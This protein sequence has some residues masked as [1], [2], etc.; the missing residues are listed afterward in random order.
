LE[1][2]RTAYRQCGV[3]VTYQMQSVQL[4][5]V[6]GFDPKCQGR[7]SFSSQQA[8]LRRLDKAMQAFFRRVKARQTPGYPRFRGVGWFNT[9]EF[10]KDG[11][12]VRWDATPHDPVTRV[13]L[14]GVGHV[15][16]HQHRPVTGIVKTVSVK[17]EGT[18]WFVILSCDDVPAQPLPATGKTVG[19]DM[20]TAHF[21]TTSHGQHVP[22][23]RYGRTTA[24]RLTAAQQ[25]LSRCQRRSGR[26]KK[27]AARVAVLHGRVRRQRLDHAHKT[28]R[29]LIDEFDVIAHE[30]LRIANMV[31]TPKPKP[32]PKQSG[33]FLPNGAAARAGL[34]RSIHDA[35]W[36]VFLGILADKADSAGRRV[37]PVDPRD[38]SRTCPDCGHVSGDNRVTQAEFVCVACGYTANADVVGALNVEHRAGLVL[39]EGPAA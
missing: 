26:R 6:R 30:E 35:G 16:V 25:A 3:T 7:W 38:T 23:P 14:R 10:P 5:D 13:R 20:G 18:R 1:E 24:D 31:R 32:D 11:D 33:A 12:G 27:A 15:R 29:G 37:I 36:G 17:R 19:I 2:R 28:A 39:R 4:K 8:T 21:L 9:V 22:N 34:N